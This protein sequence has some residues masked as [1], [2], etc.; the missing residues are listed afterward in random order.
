M[1]KPT[2]AVTENP[3]APAADLTPAQAEAEAINVAL[4]DLE[5][6]PVTF[7]RP[8]IESKTFTAKGGEISTNAEGRDWLLAHV[9]GT[10][11]A[12]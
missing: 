6:G 3:D 1:P 10:P 8:G 2:P 11:A 9:V 12:D 4:P 5:D 7:T